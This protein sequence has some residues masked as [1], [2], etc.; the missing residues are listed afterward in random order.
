[1]VPGDCCR[2]P[3]GP[4]HSGHR[5]GER[6]E[7]RHRADRGGQRPS[8][9]RPAPAARQRAT[10]RPQGR[11]ETRKAQPVD[12]PAGEG[13]QRR[14]QGDRRGHDD[15]DGE[16]GRYC[17]ARRRGLPQEDQ[18]QQ[19]DHHGR[20]GD[21]HAASRGAHRLPHRRTR[22]ATAARKRSRSA[23]HSGSPRRSRS[24]RRRPAP[25]RSVRNR[26]VSRSRRDAPEPKQPGMTSASPSA[27]PAAIS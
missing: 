20:V 19:G 1:M 27:Q 22:L 10:L 18:A 2:R 5:S 9:D 15:E 7:G 16:A 24:A 14:Q 3:G 11:A 17:D 6:Q 4:A 26:L 21:E 8:L 13:Q 23:A 25:T 12:A